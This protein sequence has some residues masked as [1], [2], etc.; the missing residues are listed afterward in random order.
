ML[1]KIY[2]L[3]LVLSLQKVKHLFA[4]SLI[5][6][7]QFEANMRAKNL[8]I[9]FIFFIKLSL[10]RHDRRN[11]QITSKLKWICFLTFSFSVYQILA[12]FLPPQKHKITME[13]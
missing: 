5:L 9:F 7:K 13:K 12:F 4:G 6:V 11:T 1:N 8:E 3:Y 2:N 10:L